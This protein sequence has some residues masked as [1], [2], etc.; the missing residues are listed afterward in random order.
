MR[1]DE[2]LPAA[3]ADIGPWLRDLGLDGCVDVHTHFLPPPVQRA[4]WDYFDGLDDPAWPVVYRGDEG[5]RLDVLRGVG[6][7]AC[8]ALAYAHRPG[9][10]A[11]LNDYTLDLAER[12]REIVPTFT[13]YPEP[14]VEEDVEHALQRGGRVAKVHLQVGRF[15]ADDPRLDAVWSRLAATRVPV[16]LHASAVYGVDG[17]DEYCGVGEVRRLLDAHPDLT[18]VI[19]HLGAP[20][21]TAFLGLA[22]D[23]DGV[24]L[25]TAM[26][27]TDPL[28]EPLVGSWNR[29]LAERVAALA[30]RLLFG[31]DFPSIPHRYVAQVRGVARLPLDDAALRAVLR[32]NAERLLRASRP[33][34][35]A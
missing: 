22:E 19:A 10:A 30:D 14:S 6:V 25:D 9:M 12:E 33:D 26:A 23:V 24:H 5:R 31:S 28:Y 29:D 16:V 35:G 18:L 7:E 21:L 1:R 27:P 4:V 8:T 11:W 13:F 3:D 34:L 15:H 32:G 20:D 17:G 2:D